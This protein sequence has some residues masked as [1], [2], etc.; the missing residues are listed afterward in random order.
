M[1]VP[2]RTI[3]LSD[4]LKKYYK[5]LILAVLIYFPIFGRLGFLPIRIWDEARLAVNAFEMYKDG[6]YIV[7]HYEGQPDMWNTKPP[8]TI[9][10]EVLSMKLFGVSE[11]AFRLPS[12]IAALL[13]CCL[14]L[15]ICVHYLKSFRLGFI[16]VMVLVTCNGYIEVHGTRTGDYD[17][18]LTL[19]TT[20]FCFLFYIFL[21]NN[22]TKYYYAFF[23]CVT[24]A[25]LTKSVTGL[26]FGPAL[27]LYA[28]Y[29]KKLLAL[30]KNPHTYAGLAI[31]A[32]FAGGY[33]L[34]RESQNHGYLK[35]VW[36]NELGGRYANTIEDH[37]QPV[38]YYYNNF[39]DFQLTAW[40]LLVPCGAIL[41]F[42]LKNER[43]RKIAQYSTLLAV[44][45]FA[46]IS[47]ASTKLEWYDLPLYP[48]LAILI[49]VCINFLFDLVRDMKIVGQYL[50]YNSAPLALLIFLFFTP[51]HKIF[52]KTQSK[53]EPPYYYDYTLSHYLQDAASGK[54]E[55]NNDY[56]LYE[57]YNAQNL[58]Y[59]MLLQE[60]GI[61][62]SMKDWTKLE[63]GDTVV[64]FQ[65]NLRN[66][67]Y[68]TY[69]HE[70]LSAQGWATRIKIKGRKPTQ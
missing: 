30:L 69:E 26:M 12:A 31:V 6:S 54:I 47:S 52:K 48:F 61:K 5:Y 23:I 64:V 36:V 3:N 19:F 50:S 60:K 65:E 18:M 16:V 55:C 66:Y 33:Y 45:F 29:Q 68:G 53:D 38:Q 41:G 1:T 13:T 10:C 40:Y 70:W 34:L 59:V 37:K 46:I 8:L 28:L 43:L 2:E 17:S 44:V 27:V 20:A 21:E 35:A 9:W 32:I 11:A 57:G 25:I 24:L 7:T 4:I 51:Y 39:I 58:F 67:V 49:G 15:Y 56:L 14:L 22:Q 42:Y 62:F 63:A